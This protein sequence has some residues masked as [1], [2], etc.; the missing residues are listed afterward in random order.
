MQNYVSR[1]HGLSLHLLIVKLSREYD[2]NDDKKNGFHT[3]Y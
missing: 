2:I 3:K 1:D